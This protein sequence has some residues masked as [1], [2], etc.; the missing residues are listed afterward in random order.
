MERLMT[1]TRISAVLGT[2]L[3]A[4]KPKHIL[5]GL[6][7]AALVPL[8]AGAERAY[9]AEDSS[10]RPQRIALDA[11]PVTFTLSGR[12]QLQI[13]AYA[14][15]DSRLSDGIPAEIEGFRLRRARLGLGAEY[16]GFS[17]GVEADLLESEGTVLHEAFF[18]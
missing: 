6:M 14:G 15:G 9:S 4:L 5:T 7:I 1:S 17:V 2:I 12:T 3:G 16:K 18:G 13:T 8:S 10:G 11:G